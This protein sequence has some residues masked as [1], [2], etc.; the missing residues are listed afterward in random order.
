MPPIQLFY[1]KKQPESQTP[2]PAVL[3]NAARFKIK[4]PNY[5]ASEPVLD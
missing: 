1:L 2:I 4:S 5:W 3:H